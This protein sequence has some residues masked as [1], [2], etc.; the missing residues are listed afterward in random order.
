[1]GVVRGK[2]TSSIVLFLCLVS[3][4]LA[5]QTKLQPMSSSPLSHL[6]T[7]TVLIVFVMSAG[8]FGCLF[9][10]HWRQRPAE[11]VFP[12]W[13]F[14]NLS[15]GCGALLFGLFAAEGPNFTTAI[16]NGLMLLSSP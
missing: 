12:L 4:P 2:L 5:S 14:A 1:M 16:A 9:L 7:A 8:I 10:F 11:V 6:D 15:C 3:I 13:G